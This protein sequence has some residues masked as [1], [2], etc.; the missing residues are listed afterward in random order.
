MEFLCKPFPI[1]VW[2]DELDGMAL[3]NWRRVSVCII[4]LKQLSRSL[5][6]GL[7]TP[8]RVA[9]LQFFFL[10]FFL[11]SQ[12]SRHTMTHLGDP[13][14]KSTFQVICSVIFFIGFIPPLNIKKKYSL[15]LFF[16]VSKQVRKK[17]NKFARF[18]FVELVNVIMAQ[19]RC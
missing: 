13:L 14:Q 17:K 10:F 4:P 2:L 5:G 11:P 18:F 3:H 9:G 8:L 7:V 1:K 19:D 12:F 6:L 15:P 16:N